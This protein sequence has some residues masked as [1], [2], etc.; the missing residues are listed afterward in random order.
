MKIWLVTLGTL[1]LSL[2]LCLSAN[3][4]TATFQT[5]ADP[6]N[7][8][9]SNFALSGDGSVMA[10]IYGGEI[11]RWTAAT[12]FQDLGPG[13]PYAPVIGISRD[14]ST[15]I[16]GHIGADGFSS[17]TIWRGTRSLDLGHPANGCTA[18]GNSWGT[19]YSL[20]GDGAVAVGLAWTCTDA[21]GFAWYPK[22]GI[23]SLGHPTGGANSRASAISANAETIVG[24]WEDATGSRH[25]VR[26][27][28]KQRDFFLGP[29][30]IGEAWAVTSNGTQIAGQTL[31]ASGVPVAFSYSDAGGLVMI[32]T[33]SHRAGDQSWAN[34]ISD[35]GRVVGWSGNQFGQG[36]EAF[37]WT[38]QAGMKKL[39]TLLNELGA[40]IPAG[41]TLTTAISISADGSTIVGQS[42]D[43]SNNVR[44]WIAHI[45]N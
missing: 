17:P 28:G 41:T 31:D 8:T 24:F 36:I 20:S 44:N 7:E 26:W 29:T 33:L 38:P 32:G 18:I 5:I 12:G 9:W 6:V 4:T 37:I 42:V 39:S 25:P 23:G 15:I 3:A 30:T 21:E 40:N 16:S 43:S 13:D 45:T 10:A 19:G 35:K 2:S 27:M 11:Y 34:G 1:C 22:R 14:G